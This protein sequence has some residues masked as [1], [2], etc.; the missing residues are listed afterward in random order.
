RKTG[1]ALASPR[2]HGDRASCAFHFRTSFQC[3]TPRRRTPVRFH[4][5]PAVS[6]WN[7][8]PSRRARVVNNSARLTFGT[9]AALDTRSEGDTDDEAYTRTRTRARHRADGNRRER[10]A[11]GPRGGSGAA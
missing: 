10:G 7:Q 5:E 8:R 1:A 2:I 9:P 11:G 4:R 3:G 6:T